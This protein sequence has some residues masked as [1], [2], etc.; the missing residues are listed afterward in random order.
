MAQLTV[1]KVPDE[2]VK[3]LRIQA[4]K[5][6]RSAEAEHRRI[7]ENA[8]RGGAGDFWARADALRGSLRPQRTD[9]TALIRESR[10]SR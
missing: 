8:L 4:A 5:N 2:I 3:A 9:S 6:G 1:R 7:L 10:N